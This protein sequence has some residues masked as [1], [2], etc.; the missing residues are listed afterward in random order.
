MI[1][2]S[3]LEKQIG[4][5]LYKRLIKFKKNPKAPLIS[6]DELYG[7]L[8]R[9]EKNLID[10]ICSVEPKDYGKNFTIFYGIK[11]VP[12]DIVAI[13]NQKYF[14]AKDNKVETVKRQYLPRLVYAA[15]LKMKQAMRKDLGTSINVVS[16]YRSPAY[17]AVLLMTNLFDNNWGMKATLRRLT[18]PGCSEHGYPARQAVDI[19]PE[20]KII[21]SE[22]FD[23]TEEYKWLQK[24]AKRF[25]FALSYPKGN[26]YGVMFEPWHWRYATKHKA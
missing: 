9:E 1:G 19:G 16:G 15:F 26:K 22:V 14:S 7:L 6:F 13:D 21:K 12:K 2:F 23:Q 3:Q 20:K 5:R 4:S 25:G 8:T 17:Q 11:P 10:K 18:L 24:N